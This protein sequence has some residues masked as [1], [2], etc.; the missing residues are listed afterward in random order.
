MLMMEITFYYFFF[1]EKIV[2]LIEE[3]K[4]VVLSGETGCGKTTQVKPTENVSSF[5]PDI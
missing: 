4:V 5:C 3:N 1:R 2:N